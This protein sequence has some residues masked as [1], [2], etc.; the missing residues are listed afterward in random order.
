MRFSPHSRF[1]EIQ[2]EIDA[3][4]SK[5]PY[6][7]RDFVDGGEYKNHPKHGIYAFTDP[8]N[9]EIV[10]IGKSISHRRSR[11]AGTPP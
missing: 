5:T 2:N 6:R 7:V 10:Y 9:K 4:L 11:R 1:P 8:E 3:L